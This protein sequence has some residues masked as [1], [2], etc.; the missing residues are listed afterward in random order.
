MHTHTHTERAHPMLVACRWRPLL[1]NVR[2][3]FFLYLFQSPK[4]NRTRSVDTWFSAIS[5][6]IIFL[7]GVNGPV[8]RLGGTV[9]R[10][11][12]HQQRGRHPKISTV[13]ASPSHRFLTRPAAAATAVDALSSVRRR[14]AIAGRR[15]D[16]SRSFGPSAVVA[17]SQAVSG[18]CSTLA[19]RHRRC[20]RAQRTAATFRPVTTV[21]RRSRRRREIQT[22]PLRRVRGERNF[23]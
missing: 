9:A 13:A 7:L 6:Y 21:F 16:D 3:Y 19:G 11:S 8:T 18:C 5:F 1:T 2:S 4:K 14:P 12:R 17:L 22:E 20:P 15:R 23:R 10:R